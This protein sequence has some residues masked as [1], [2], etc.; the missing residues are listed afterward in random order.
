[1]SHDVVYIVGPGSDY[2]PEL[3]YSLRSVAANLPHRQVWIVGHKPSWVTNVNWVPTAQPS[4]VKYRNSLRNLIIAC[5]QDDLTTTF[6]LFNDDF[7]A[8]HP[9]RHA[10]VAH[11]GTLTEMLRAAKYRTR[12]TSD[13][14]HALHLVRTHLQDERGITDPLSYELHVPMPINKTKF[15]NVIDGYEHDDMMVGVAKRSLYGNLAGIGGDKMKD[16]RPV[17]PGFWN[18][19]WI[20]SNDESFKPGLITRTFI[21][22]AFPTRC[23]YE[24]KTTAPRTTT[25]AWVNTGLLKPGA[26]RIRTAQPGSSLAERLDDEPTWL[27]V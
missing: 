15:L 16:P 6:T 19:D 4:R 5:Q 18:W 8:M 27:A 22:H 13:Y 9:G 11:R 26:M 7:Y 20:S 24:D 3:R 21:E 2:H 23:Q 12:K 14:L 10:P 25:R 17:A 1:M